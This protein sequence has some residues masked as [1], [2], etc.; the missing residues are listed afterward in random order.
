MGTSLEELEQLVAG[1]YACATASVQIAVQSCLELLG[2]RVDVI[3]V[4]MPVT[5]APDTLAAVLRA[6]GH[7]LLLDIEEEHLQLDPAQL[8]DAL[9]MLEEQ[10]RVPVILFNRPF[11]APVREEL[12]EM[13]L[14]YPSI[15]DSR[16][17]PHEKLTGLD[18]CC[19]FNVFDLSTVCEAGALIIHKFPEQVD[20]LKMVRSGPM[21]LDG[22]LP[23]MLAKEAVY[24]HGCWQNTRKHYWG[25]VEKFIG[26][27]H[28]VMGPSTE[29]G[30]VWL[31][32]DNARR[33]AATLKSYGVEAVLGLA[34]LYDLEEVKRR[35][36][37]EPEYPV[38]K[39]LE[40]SFV[41]FN[42]EDIDKAL[43]VL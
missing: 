8:R 16:V 28:Q 30:V 15:V 39:A 32:V 41:C 20:Q 23:E 2:T 11:R 7:P 29:P 18:I 25:E 6:G 24:V 14:D 17:V 4:I 38:T 37:E 9:E 26:T 3:P 35:Y 1:P 12:L 22:A 31:K 40:N 42:Y 34:P 19:T 10:K 33:T 13:V 36:R 5:S 43:K 27:E 21:G